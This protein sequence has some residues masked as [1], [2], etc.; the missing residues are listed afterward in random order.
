MAVVIMP[1]SVDWRRMAVKNVASRTARNRTSAPKRP[2]SADRRVRRTK[3][4]LHE[5]LVGLAREKP[6]DAIAVKEILDRADVGRSTFYDHFGDK[7]DLLE[8]GIQDMIR[9]ARESAPSRDPVERIVAFS[10]AVLGHIN[11]HRQSVGPQM[12]RSS[13]HAFH[14][15][16][17]VALA[18]WIGTDVSAA[19]VRS[20][21][22][23]AVSPEL[24]AHHVASTFVLVLNWWVECEPALTP[25]QV[26][27]RFR[28]LVLPALRALI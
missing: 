25:A 1:V 26:D 22:L 21:S 24:V 4:S 5:A 18:D 13:Q 11:G 28:A 12:V 16:L 3:R 20:G 17:E 8:S 6:Y 7:D 10:L 15:R 9:A 27:A 19:L 14:R 2:E 23:R